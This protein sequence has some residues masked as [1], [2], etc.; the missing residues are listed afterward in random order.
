MISEW[1]TG[2]IKSCSTH[3]DL[4]NPQKWNVWC[5]KASK[6]GSFPWIEPAAVISTFLQTR[7]TSK[8]LN[9]WETYRSLLSASW[10]ALISSNQQIQDGHQGCCGI[11]KLAKLD[12]CVW[13]EII[14][15]IFWT[16]EIIYIFLISSFLF[17]V[18][19]FQNG[20]HGCTGEY[21]FAHKSVAVVIV[22]C[23]SS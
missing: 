12:G 8:Q 20:R 1:L 19:I 11:K 23:G 3:T 7:L 6:C 2:L 14:A 18:D 4:R 10:P 22:S 13:F 9:V 5:G 17:P 21:M 16:I 15:Y